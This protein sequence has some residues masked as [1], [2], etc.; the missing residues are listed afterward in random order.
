MSVSIMKKLTVLAP[1]RDADAIVRRLV[2]LR[3]V[4]LGTTAAEDGDLLRVNCDTAK[5]EAEERI[6]KVSDAISVLNGYTEE[7]KGWLGQKKAPDA[8]AFRQSG[9]YDETWSVVNETLTLRDRVEA[10]KTEEAHLRDRFHALRPWAERYSSPLDE[11]G[12]DSCGVWLGTVPA[13]IPLS[14]ISDSLHDLHVGVEDVGS[15]EN[16]TYLSLVYLKEDEAALNRVLGELEFVRADFAAAGLTGTARECIRDLRARRKEVREERTQDT[17][18]LKELGSKVSDLEAL[19]DIEMNDLITA[20]E[21]A[22]LV[23]TGA[24]VML[25]GWVPAARADKVS[26]ALDRQFCAYDLTEPAEEDEPPVLLKNNGYASNFEWVVAMYSYPKYGT[27]DPTFIMS[28][29]YFFIFGL[30]FADVGYGLILI[31][32]GLLLPKVLHMKDSMRRMFNMFGYCGF[33]SV[34]MGVLFGGWFGDLPYALMVNIGQSFPTTEAAKAAFP[35]F[36]G[37]WVNPINDPMTFLIISLGMGAIHLVAGMAVKF[38]LLCKEKKVFEAIFGIASW[39]VIF[40]GIAV[41][42]LVNKTVGFIVMGVGALMIICTAGREEKNPLMKFAKGLLGLYDIINYA[43]DL[44]SYSRILA[45]GLTSVVIAQVFNLLATMVGPTVVGIIV[46]I[47]VLVIGHI[48]NIA[49]NVL[50]AFVHT[51]RLQYLEFFGKFFEDGG[52]GFK[53]ALPSETYTALSDD[54]PDA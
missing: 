42:A 32:G 19:Y 9:A 25:E 45:L 44:L 53:P 27:Y 47:V 13:R 29:F 30:M 23:S 34:I 40:A 39:W 50:G 41:L 51:S 38:V 22:K 36:D 5:A 26:A 37:L 48:L 43:S 28:I 12:T 52:R 54:G 1:E 11:S 18:R 49:I 3:C 21:K 16:V 31:L 24:C 15:D 46:M 6:R 17:A 8:A 14:Q 35:L 7:A 10:G 2:R 20:Q 33:S 4:E